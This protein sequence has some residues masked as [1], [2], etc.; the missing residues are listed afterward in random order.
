MAKRIFSDAPDF[1]RESIEKHMVNKFRLYQKRFMLDQSRFRIANKAR[2]IGFSYLIGM[3]MIIGALLRKKNQLIVSASQENAFIVLDHIRQHLKEMHIEAFSDTNEE[4]IMPTGK[5]IK[6]LATNWK[7]ARGFAGDVYFDEFAFMIH[8]SEVW[9]ALVPA[10]TAAHGRITVVSTPKSRIDKFWEIWENNAS[11]SKHCITIHDAVAQGLNINLE[12]LKSLFTPEEFAMAYECLPLDTTDSYISYNLI[13]PCIQS[14][15]IS[16]SE[17][18]VF[19]ADIGRVK[20]ETAIIGGHFT[21]D[22]K[23]VVSY[24]RDLKKC[25]FYDQKLTMVDLIKTNNASVFAIDRGGIGYNLWEDLSYIYPSIIRGY[26]FAPAVKE[27]LAKNLKRGFEEKRLSIP[28]DQ[29][30]I[31]HI[32]SIKRSA[33]R[34]NIFSYNAEAKEHHGDKFWALAMLFDIVNNQK[35]IDN[36]MLF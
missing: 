22:N 26:S 7:T 30:L 10:I 11:F 9:K 24:I 4:I 29:S 23:L 18:N 34:T 12:E 15:L 6:A 21:D 35:T 19:A 13:E 36:V 16:K 27:R 32:L 28:N 25:P 1:I 33:N 5:V 8:D 2:Q 17:N 31:N 3:E 20:D 14:H